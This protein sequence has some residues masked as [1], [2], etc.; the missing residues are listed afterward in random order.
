MAYTEEQQQAFYL[1][2][3][4]DQLLYQ[5]EGMMKS[6]KNPTNDPIV[7]EITQGQFDVQKFRRLLR[8]WKVLLEQIPDEIPDKL[9]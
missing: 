2:E 3:K 8:R 5:V 1:I 6:R 7:F 9:E 4:L